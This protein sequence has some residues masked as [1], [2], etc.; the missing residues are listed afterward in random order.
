MTKLRNPYTYPHRSRKAMSEYITGIG[1]Y[2]RGYREQYP[3]EFTVAADGADLSADHLWET[4][5]QEFAPS[6]PAAQADYK[7]VFNAQHAQHEDDLFYQAIEDARNNTLDA[8]TYR[9]LWDDTPVNVTL[10]FHGRG[11]K[12][13]CIER[14]EGYDLKGVSEEGLL[15]SLLDADEWPLDSLRKFYKY[16]RQCAV[17]F[18]SRNAAKEVEYQAAFI[19]FAS[20]VDPAYAES[21]DDKIKAEQVFQALKRVAVALDGKESGSM[22][23]IAL[24]CGVSAEIA[25]ND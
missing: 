20:F 8:D 18:T 10:G 22:A 4:Y 5:L 9:M 15:D 19:L 25:Q 13:L 21:K 14:F 7:S 1:G 6:D 24:A 11:G 17:D 23:V 12:H 16:V 2:S 3:I